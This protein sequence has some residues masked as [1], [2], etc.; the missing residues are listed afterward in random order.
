MKKTFKMQN[1]DCANCA[2]KM[3]QAIQ[4]IPGVISA[5][6]SFMTQKLTLEYDETKEAEI[7]AEAKKACQKVDRA[8]SI[9]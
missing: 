9:L 2:A 3:E 5:N 4:K 1:L 7:L 6:I 8:C